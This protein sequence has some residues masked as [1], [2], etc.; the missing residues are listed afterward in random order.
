LRREIF[1]LK[2]VLLA[3]LALVEEIMDIKPEFKEKFKKYVPLLVRV[4]L[5]FHL[6]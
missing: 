5:L 2:G 3:T 1:D 6:F 4:D